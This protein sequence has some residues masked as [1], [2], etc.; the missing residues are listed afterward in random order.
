MVCFSSRGILREES[1]QCSGKCG[2]C[3]EAQ[4]VFSNVRIKEMPLKT[5][6]LVTLLFVFTFALYQL[7]PRLVLSQNGRDTVLAG[8]TRDGSAAERRWEEQFRALPAPASAREHLRRLTAEPHV[9]GTKEDYATAVYVRDQ[10]RS[11]G[12]QAEL[13]EYQVWLNYSKTDTIVELIA[14]RREHLSVREGI[15]E[16]DPNCWNG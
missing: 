15:L 8:F 10:M 16:E 1:E 4:Q 3:G 7:T 12:L 13:K 6:R 5:T 9:A 14:P 11:F 2:P